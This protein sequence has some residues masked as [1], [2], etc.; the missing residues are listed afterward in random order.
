MMFTNVYDRAAQ[1][2]IADSL[3]SKSCSDGEA[4]RGSWYK[5]AGDRLLWFGQ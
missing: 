2:E 5:H 4:A 3:S 1:R